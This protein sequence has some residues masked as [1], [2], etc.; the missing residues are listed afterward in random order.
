MSSPVPS[1]SPDV[2]DPPGVRGSVFDQWEKVARSV[3]VRVLLYLTAATA[4]AYGLWRLLGQKDET[5]G[6][7]SWQFW[8]ALGVAIIPALATLVGY[9]IPD[10]RARRRRR[11][12]HDWSLSGDGGMSGHFRLAP[13]DEQDRG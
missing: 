7:G 13:Y 1:P 8:V 3:Q 2:P 9:A 5:F 10:W 12:L 4:T 6:A 11:R